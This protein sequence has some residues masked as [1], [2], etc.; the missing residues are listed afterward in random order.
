MN[1]YTKSFTITLILYM[2]IF[3]SF[4]YSFDTNEQ[5]KSQQTKS[6]QIVKFTIIQQTIKKVVKKNPPQ[7]ISAKKLK[8]IEKKIKKVVHKKIEKKVHKKEPVIAKKQ[9]KQ[10]KSNNIKNINHLEE[11]KQKK[12][13]QKI[14]YTKIKELINKNK[15][16]P[17]IAVR[18]GI[19]GSVKIQ[20]TI[21]K[22]GELLTFKIIEGKKV[23]EKSIG[24]AIQKSFPLKPPQGTLTSNTQ[25]SLQLDYRLY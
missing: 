2:C 9:I 1:R 6:E 11:L 16:Y 15:Y 25:L 24:T 8:P 21:S 14:Y 13:N 3:I 7:E 23:F 5:I 4:V 10:N 12:S 18:R 22:D 20:F 17:K 19:E